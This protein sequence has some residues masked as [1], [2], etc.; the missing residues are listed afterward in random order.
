MKKPAFSGCAFPMGAP[1]ERSRTRSCSDFPRAH[2]R[3]PRPR[4]RS[5][6][7]LQKR[8]DGTLAQSRNQ[9]LSPGLI[10]LLLL[11]NIS[12]YEGVQP[13]ASQPLREGGHSV[14]SHPFF[15]TFWNLIA[16]QS[17]FQRTRTVISPSA[18]TEMVCMRAPRHVE[19]S[20]RRRWPIAGTSSTTWLTRWSGWP[21][22]CWRI[23]T[24]TSSRCPTF[25][26]A[27][28]S[29]TSRTERHSLNSTV[30]PTPCP[31]NRLSCHFSLPVR[32]SS[33]R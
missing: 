24:S 21:C 10:K 22:A 19:R 18:G 13:R 20:A 1:L 25:I 6:P 9:S 15:V 27:F 14:S 3:S 5:S 8:R 26:P 17:A 32:K 30:S 12:I 2:A 7:V 33:L 28:T 16:R 23:H 29:A 31:R 11:P 4:L